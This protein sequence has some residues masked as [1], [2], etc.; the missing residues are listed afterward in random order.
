MLYL[1]PP[2]DGT[3]EVRFLEKSMDMLKNGGLA[4]LVV[5]KKTV[6]AL[7]KLL[8]THFN[9]I[10]IREFPMPERQVFGQVVVFASKNTGHISAGAQMS[11]EL[12][13][14]AQG[15]FGNETYQFR[16]TDL[17][18]QMKVWP[19]ATDQGPDFGLSRVSARELLS[20]AR[21]HGHWTDPVFIETLR[22]ADGSIASRPLAPL[23]MG[24]L[25]QYCAA[26]LLN[27]TRIDDIVICGTATKTKSTE[28]DDE[29]QVIRE[30]IKL[31]V[32]ALDLKNWTTYQIN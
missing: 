21:Q 18:D 30:K 32:M 10:T 28:E 3:V 6:R 11:A 29:K 13:S 12:D 23:R 14:Y 5:Q 24:H 8:T 16:S 20:I 31:V 26:G 22:P 7:S 27:N 2:Y 9:N 17:A 25:A 1:N 19:S 15:E 4:I